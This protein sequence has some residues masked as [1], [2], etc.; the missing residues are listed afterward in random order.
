VD[1]SERV[2][3]RRLQII[4]CLACGMA[5]DINNIL[6]VIRGTVDLM[7]TR[8]MCEPARRR[9]LTAMGRAAEGGAA[10]TRRVL[11]FGRREEVRPAGV[12]LNATLSAVKDMMAALV[13]RHVRVRIIP[14]RAVTRVV[15]NQGDL[16]LLLFNL[17]ANA[18]DAMRSRG[19]VVIETARLDAAPRRRH[20]TVP[21][22]IRSGAY[23][24]LTVRDNGCGM[25]PRTMQR[26]HAAFFTTKKRGTGLGLST[27][28]GIVEAS[29]GYLWIDSRPGNGTAVNILLPAATT[30]RSR[31]TRVRRRSRTAPARPASAGRAS[32]RST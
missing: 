9:M 11:A 2:H 22:P 29:R 32:G 6:G 4:G 1:V 25:D 17:L 21:I 23:T 28:K 27:V 31:V 12:D 16:E 5:H 26:A 14:A 15:I 13:G 30:P 20:P 24:R 10:W 3:A 18:R 19:E 8:A 7:L